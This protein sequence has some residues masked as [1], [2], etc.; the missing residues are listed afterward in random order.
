MSQL[1]DL[2]SES[3]ATKPRR[4][5]P[6]TV[7]GGALG[8]GKTTV[9][10]SI[11]RQAGG[12]RIAV[13]VNDFGAIDIDANL[14]VER[15]TRTLSLENG[16]ICCSLQDDLTSAVLEILS[17]TSLPDALLIEASGVANPRA[18]ALVLNRLHDYHPIQLDSI[19]VIADSERI[20]QPVN[21]NEQQF[22][23]DQL[24]TANSVLI[25]KRD[26]VDTTEYDR[27]KALVSEVA[28]G[29]RIIDAENGHVPIDLLL[30]TGLADRV[31]SRSPDAADHGLTVDTWS[32]ASDRPFDV[33]ELKSAIWHLP[34]GIVRA[35][36]IIRLGDDPT[37]PMVF[38]L[39]G[40]R[41][42]LT[43]LKTQAALPR[44]PATD[45]TTRVVVI[46]VEGSVHPA[47]LE[48]LFVAALMKS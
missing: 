3:R 33:R 46:G 10:N 27:V 12:R 41:A 44:T 31:M 39:V 7:L 21:T 24:R 30:D 17:A 45:P 43:P 35:K 6:V 22:M 47:E 37:R 36:G 20:T 19:A 16:C 4:K 14:V 26:L 15:T 29:V 40:R 32:F 5:V 1:A 28:P 48:E 25:T 42:T 23:L 13:I 18:V 38:Q 9:V 2:D 11:L 8:A 34:R